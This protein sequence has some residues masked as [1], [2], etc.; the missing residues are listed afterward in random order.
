M[1]KCK[2]KFTSRINVIVIFWLQ[3]FSNYGQLHTNHKK[4]FEITQSVKDIKSIGLQEKSINTTSFWESTKEVQSTAKE[5][6][7]ESICALSGN[8]IPLKTLK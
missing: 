2:K 3:K 8:T 7:S 4:F 1:K 5:A 6:L